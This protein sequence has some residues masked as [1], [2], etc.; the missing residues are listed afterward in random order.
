MSRAIFALVLLS[1]WAVAADKYTG[2]RPPKADVL[3]LLHADNL[4]ETE[5]GKAK[6]DERKD[7]VVAT[8]PGPSS[9]VKTPLAE[10]VFII[11]SDKISPDKLAAFRLEVKNGQREV[12]IS[13]KKLKNMKA[14]IHLM[15]TRLDDRL[16]RVE[17]DEVLENGEY[18]VSPDGSDETFSFQIY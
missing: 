15:V 3:Y 12:V 4:V 9:P 1:S 2:P 18:S 11:K 5:L 6:N 14:P 13:A 8:L 17:V 16:Y 7:T 10:P